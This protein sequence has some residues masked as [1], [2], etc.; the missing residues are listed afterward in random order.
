MLNRSVS[1]MLAEF[2]VSQPPSNQAQQMGDGLL[3]GVVFGVAIFAAAII[4]LLVYSSFS[5]IRDWVNEQVWRFKYRS[6]K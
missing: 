1:W 6:K 3:A 5:N 2:T 4:S